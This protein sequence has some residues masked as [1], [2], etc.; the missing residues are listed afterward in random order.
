MRHRHDSHSPPPPRSSPP[1][2]TEP[3]KEYVVSLRALNAAGNGTPIYETLWT[4]QPMRKPIDSRPLVIPTGLKVFIVSESA[5][6]LDFT[7]RSLPNQVC[8][9]RS[10]P[11]GPVRCVPRTTHYLI[12]Y[13]R[14]V[15]AKQVLTLQRGQSSQTSQTGVRVIFSPGLTTAYLP[16]VPNK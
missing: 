12:R 10:L 14:T 9:E 11:T 7:D 1:P 13:V 5:A 4:R 16:V 6:V 8:T 2:L 15:I 3:N